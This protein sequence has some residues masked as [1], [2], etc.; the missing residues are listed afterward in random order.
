MTLPPVAFISGEYSPVVVVWQTIIDR[1]LIR[2]ERGTGPSDQACS[3]LMTVPGIGP[4]ISS[5]MVA[6]IGMA[7]VGFSFEHPTPSGVK[8]T[9]AK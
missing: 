9:A 6:A 3:R 8:M 7:P 2:R 5:D 4:I 1:W